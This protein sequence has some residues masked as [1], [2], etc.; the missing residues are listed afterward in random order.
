MRFNE[1]LWVERQKSADMEI[2]SKKLLI[3]TLQT[4]DNTTMKF[5]YEAPSCETI[6][7]MAR[8][9]MLQDSP[10]WFLGLPGMA[11]AEEEYDESGEDY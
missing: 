2:E 10:L 9:A 3:L 5:D 7:L 8:Q 6:Q 11:G 4:T 1:S